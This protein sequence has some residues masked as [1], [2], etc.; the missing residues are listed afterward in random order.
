MAGRGEGTGALIEPR[1]HHE[2][3][4]WPCRHDHPSITVVRP[5]V[6]ETDQASHTEIRTLPLGLPVGPSILQCGQAP[7]H[8]DKPGPVPSLTYTIPGAPHWLR[9]TGLQ[10]RMR[11]NHPVPC[12]D[13]PMRGA[14]LGGLEEWDQS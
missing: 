12:H 14:R 9:P 10:A 3:A 1:N 13:A 2:Q 11:W 7:I 8:G 6:G 4:S 5:M